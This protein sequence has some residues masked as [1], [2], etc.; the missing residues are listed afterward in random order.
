MKGDKGG[1]GT[2]W[3]GGTPWAERS[4]GPRHRGVSCVGGKFAGW[5]RGD[6]LVL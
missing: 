2:G 6:I 3:F 5:L 4:G 1:S